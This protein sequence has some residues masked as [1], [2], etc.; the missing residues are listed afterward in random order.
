VWTWPAVDADSK[1]M[2]SWRVESRDSLMANASMRDVAARLAN[3]VRLTTDSYSLY[4]AA[5]ESAFLSKVDYA[6][7]HNIYKAKATAATA[8]PSASAAR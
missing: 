2:V 8:R 3:R 1:L 4:L 7:L 5:V 6:Q